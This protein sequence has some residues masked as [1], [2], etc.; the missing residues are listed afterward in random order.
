[1]IARLRA[2]EGG[3]ALVAALVLMLV[4]GTFAMGT[5]A[6][7]DTQQRQ[8]ATGRKRETAFNVSE[9]ALNAQMFA[10]SRSWPGPGASGN[11]ALRYPAQCTETSTD[12]RC[13]STSTLTA[14]YASPDTVPN[15]TWTSMVRDNSGSTGAQTFWSESMVTTAPTY[16][17]NGDG[18]LWVRAT[19]IV[20][21]KRR[22]MVALVRTEPQQ[23]DLP[24]VTVLAGSLVISNNGHKKLI[25]T[26]G[27][28]AS[29]GPIQVRCDPTA[30]LSFSC[31]GHQGTFS[32]NKSLLDIQIVPDVWSQWTGGA[33]MTPAQLSRLKQTAI[34]NGTYFTSCP[35]SLAGAVVYIEA[36][37]SC[38]YTA[39]STF[40]SA[41]APGLVVMT[42]GTLSLGGTVNFYGVLYHANLSGSSGTLVTTQGNAQVQGGVIVD[43]NGVLTVGSSGVN[44]IFDDS[45]F[46]RVA[47]YGN[48]GLVQNTWR[49]VR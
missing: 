41:T 42:G 14:M 11:A 29:A 16:D 36:S 22:T 12:S 30:V 44:L 31:L 26:R 49:E 35:A 38:S 5:L 18:K 9:A 19:S 45:A 43:G 3:W 20:M 7:V 39:N 21:G 34:A 40:N 47:S 37:L 23:E 4:L 25:D 48:A 46:S 32:S 27:P 33:A 24:H 28:S 10:L 13:P 2:E 8:S 6:F 1:M 15:A 17:A